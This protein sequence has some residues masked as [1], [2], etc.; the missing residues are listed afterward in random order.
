MKHT[1]G[2]WAV[3]VANVFRV[4]AWDGDTPTR[5]IVAD[6]MEDTWFGNVRLAW[7]QG[8]GAGQEAA[9]NARLIAAAPDLL[10]ACQRALTLYESY[11]FRGVHE[12]HA[13]NVEETLRAALAKVEGL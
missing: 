4:L 2:P 6:A 10:T 1:P 13:A 5:C 7:P 12:V 8:D 3:P 11:Q 9:A